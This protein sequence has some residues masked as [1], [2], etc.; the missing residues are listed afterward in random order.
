MRSLW[1][2]LAPLA[3]ATVA[4]NRDQRELESDDTA[5]VQDTDDET[6]TDY[7]VEVNGPEQPVVGDEWEVWLWCEDVLQVGAS[8]VGSDPPDFV[9]IRGPNTIEFLYA[10]TGKLRIQVGNYRHYEPVTVG[11]PPAR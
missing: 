5:I 10:G 2:R 9:A 4:C 6:C 11:E 8:V 1:L 3:C 7:H